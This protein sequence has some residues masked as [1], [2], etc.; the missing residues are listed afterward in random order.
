MPPSSN[1]AQAPA[2]TPFEPLQRRLQ[3]LLDKST[4]HTLYRWLALAAVAL[5]YA[6]RVYYLQGFY[7]VTYG[8]AIYNLNL[9]LG[10]LTPQIDPEREGPVLPSKNDEEYRPFVRKLPEFKFWFSSLKSLLVGFVAT[11]FSMF[12]VPVFWPILVMYW[13]VLFTITMKRQIK[14]MIKYR[15]IPFSFG[16]KKYGKGA[17]SAK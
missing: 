8:L 12:D 15:Y 11:F 16:K 10:F 7:I 14:H 17:K 5:L 6:L 2:K 1:G 9:F 4:P 3:V 13:L